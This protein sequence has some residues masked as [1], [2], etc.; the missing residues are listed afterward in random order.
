MNWWKTQKENFTA[1]KAHEKIGDKIGI[2]IMILLGIPLSIWFRQPWIIITMFAFFLGNLSGYEVCQC[3]LE[4]G[5]AAIILW[6]KTKIVDSIMDCFVAS[7]KS[8]VVV[9]LFVFG[10]IK[11]FG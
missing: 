11:F 10:Y 3:R 1:W 8:G 6:L 2:P 7:Y 5:K 9:V 4:T